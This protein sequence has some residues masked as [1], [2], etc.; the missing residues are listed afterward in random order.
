M[1]WVAGH[2]PAEDSSNLTVTEKVVSEAKDLADSADTKA[3][4]VG[5]CKS[6]SERFFEKPVPERV[7]HM[8]R[9]HAMYVLSLGRNMGELEKEVIRECRAVASEKCLNKS[10]GGEGIHRKSVRLCYIAVR[11]RDSPQELG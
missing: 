9:L 11:Y 1:I 6:P 2:R 8:A 10:R 4:Y 3:F 5:V 7:P